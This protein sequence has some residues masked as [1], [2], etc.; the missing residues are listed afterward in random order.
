MYRN[1]GL[2]G[3]DCVRSLD[4]PLRFVSIPGVGQVRGPGWDS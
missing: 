2:P 3:V 4:H 1:A